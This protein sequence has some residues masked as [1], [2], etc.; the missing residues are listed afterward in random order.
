MPKRSNGKSHINDHSLPL[1]NIV[2]MPYLRHN[3]IRN[4]QQGNDDMKLLSA[5]EVAEYLTERDK[6]SIKER[7]VLDEIK[8]GYIKAEKIGGRYI[9]KESSLKNYKRRKPGPIPGVRR[10]KNI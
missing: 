4:G 1:P 5:K 2:I 10:K 9:I 7:E 3:Y 6:K 8:K